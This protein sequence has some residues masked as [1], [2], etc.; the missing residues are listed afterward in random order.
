MYIRKWNSYKCLSIGHLV[1]VINNKV[2][3]FPYL[4]FCNKIV[5]ALKA[6]IPDLVP[7]VFT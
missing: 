3:K 6:T 1:T 2:N 4:L 5:S 7:T